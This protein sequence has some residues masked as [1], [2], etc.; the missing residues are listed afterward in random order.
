MLEGGVYSDFDGIQLNLP[1]SISQVPHTFKVPFHNNDP[2]FSHNSKELWSAVLWEIVARYEKCIDQSLLQSKKVEVN[3]QRYTCFLTGPG[4]MCE[5]SDSGLIIDSVI[6]NQG[7]FVRI[8]KDKGLAYNDYL[9]NF[10]LKSRAYKKDGTFTKS[11]FLRFPKSHFVKILKDNPLGKYGAMYIIDSDDFVRAVF[12][13]QTW[14][15]KKG[16]KRK[17]FVA[18][19]TLD[20]L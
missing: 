14:V 6:E 16:Q 15:G 4:L 1:R 8:K 13:G 12:Y 20:F 7:W 18:P 2:Y 5:Y 19:D 9:Q 10:V 17:G 3:D 11:D